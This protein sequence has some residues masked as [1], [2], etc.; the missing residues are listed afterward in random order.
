MPYRREFELPPVVAE[1][2]TA[3]NKLRE[4]YKGAGLNFTLD[5][6]L[7]GDIGE[8][9]AA[10]LFGI[11]LVAANGAGVDGHA[12]DGR[13]VQVKVTGTGRGPVF[14]CVDTRADHLLFFDIDFGKLRG[15]I[16]FNGPERIALAKMP[17]SWL[18]QRPVTKAQI[19]EADALV[20][21]EDRLRRLDV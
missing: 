5:G 2:V 1:L 12:A 13:S 19:R 3:R 21:I 9:V 16:V 15:K 11:K 20:R 8:A 7:V 6:N 18:G 4:H 10:E 17:K 14:R